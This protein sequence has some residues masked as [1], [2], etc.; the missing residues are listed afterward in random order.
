M[1]DPPAHG[2]ESHFI[3]THWSDGE[4]ARHLRKLNIPYSLTWLGMFSRK[5]DRRNLKMTF[6]AL[7][8]LPLAWGTFVRLYL[9]MKPDV[10]YCANHH[11][12]ILLFPLLLMLRRKVLCHMHDPPPQIPFQKASF[13]VWRLAVGRFI[14]ISES[15]RDRLALLGPIGR[16]AV[17]HNGVTIAKLTLPRERDPE[18]C[19]RFGW[20]QDVVIFGITGQ[21]HDRKGHEDFIEAARIT[22]RSSPNLRFVI[23]GRNDEEN[24]FVA[25]LKE[26]IAALEL[27]EVVVFTGWQPTSRDFYLRIDT[28]VLASRHDEGF[29]LV[30]AEAGEAGIPTIATDS[31]GV[32]EIIL[33]GVTG[34]LVPKSSPTHLAKAM[35]YLAQHREQREIMGK[36]ARERVSREFNLEIQR[37]RFFEYMSR[38]AI[39]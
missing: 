38:D 28:L 18:L 14:F 17:I 19:N 4:F 27:R 33:D 22:R 30:V 34:V 12:I 8:R 16:S 9:T 36:R 24:P 3:L 37:S 31:G 2:V 32:V 26:R 15:A 20:P 7:T 10:V 5:L 35:L 11:E 6:E 23:G 25:Q 29:G 13:S 1:F 39:A 21:L